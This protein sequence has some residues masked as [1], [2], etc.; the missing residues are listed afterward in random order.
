MFRKGS[1][2]CLNCSADIN[3][4]T[5][6]DGGGCNPIQ[7]HSIQKDG[8]I[9]IHEKDLMEDIA[10]IS[11][12]LRISINFYDCQTRPSFVPKRSP[13]KAVAIAAVALATCLATF[14]LNWS[15]NLGDKIQQDLRAYGANI[16]ILPYGE[17][18][19][20]S[21][22]GVTLPTASEERYLKMREL[23]K[24]ITFSGRTRL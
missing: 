1:I 20:I 6:G 2:I 17:S 14:L 22:Q 23:K 15:F 4:A 12:W 21:I 13:K 24:S 11:S 5:I 16:V 7:L 9:I 3:P 18:L 10:F 19:P 8:T